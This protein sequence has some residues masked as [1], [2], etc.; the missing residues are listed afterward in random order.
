MKKEN[1][2]LMSIFLLLFV[3]SVIVNTLLMSSKNL[4]KISS[5]DIDGKFESKE[6][7]DLLQLNYDTY[8][9][10]PILQVKINEKNYVEI[11]IA[12]RTDDTDPQVDYLYYYNCDS[13][14]SISFNLYRMDKLIGS[15]TINNTNRRTGIISFNNENFELT[16]T[17]TVII[18]QKGSLAYETFT[19][20]FYYANGLIKHE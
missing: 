6:I 5:I 15:Y 7:Y 20:N 8:R 11:Y 18:D 10:D 9:N 3:I 17:I 19:T 1:N 14:I 4:S 13:K 12:S 16:D 2:Y